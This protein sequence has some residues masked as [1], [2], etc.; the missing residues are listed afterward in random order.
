MISVTN[1]DVRVERP[2]EPDRQAISTLSSLFL[3][4]TKNSIKATQRATTVTS[5][6][7]LGTITGNI[8]YPGDRIPAMT[9]YF[10]NTSTDQL[11][12]FQISENQSSYSIQLPPGSY[13]AYA[14]VPLYQVGGLYSRAVLCGLD[15]SCEDHNP[16]PFDVLAGSSVEGIHI[17]DWVIPPDEL[18]F[19]NNN[20]QP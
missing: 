7:N 10:R 13:Y 6:P 20:S 2:T 4:I 15:D 18:P 17:C 1:I 9:A 8:C 5:T 3:S 14:W 19:G 12:E 11:F 16:Q